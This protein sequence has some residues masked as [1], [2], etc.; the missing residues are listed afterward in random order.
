MQSDCILASKLYQFEEDSIAQRTPKSQLY[1]DS[2][3]ALCPTYSQAI[4]EKSVSFVKTGD[5]A[6]SFYW[7]NKAIEIDPTA[8]LGYSAWM[9]IYRFHDYQGALK[10]LR[11]LD[12]L[13]PNVTNYCWG[14]NSHKLKGLCY[15]G[16]GSFKKAIEE[17]D[18]EV[19]Y[20]TKNQGENA[21]DIYTYLYRGICKFQLSQYQK[22]LI[23]F[24]LGMKQ[25]P[26]T[27]EFLFHKALVMNKLGF[28]K[29]AKRLMLIAKENFRKGNFRSD[30]YWAFPDQLYLS[31]IEE[32]LASF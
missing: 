19:D 12:S 18:Q 30:S 29:E 3:I 23:D 32:S 10:D 20:V 14:E 9:K 1:L 5:F 11:T 13:I 21:V 27:S 25:Y 17:F 6:T 8:H 24:E 7:L 15:K 31:D 22:A 4:F 16:L 26:N 2:A 28:E